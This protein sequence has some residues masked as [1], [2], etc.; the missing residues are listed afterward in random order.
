[1]EKRGQ[2]FLVAALI[3][4]SLLFGLTAV[5]NSAQGGTSPD[6][7]SDLSH[8]INFESK[9]V[10]DY[11][12]YYEQNTNQLLQQFLIRY[13]DYISQEKVLFVFGNRNNLS[14]F[15]FKRGLLGVDAI[16]TGGAP[17]SYPIQ[18]ITGAVADVHASET[19]VDATIQG[20]TYHFDLLEGQ[21]FF[22]VII[23]EANHE[24][25]VATNEGR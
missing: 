11:G 17:Q 12:V 15:F 16:V 20:V 22:F 4:A 25:F 8:E 19:G 6:G 7:I 2:F 21:N 9:Q 13:A 24:S 5:V 1:M 10:L 3:I 23:K 18:E 14:A